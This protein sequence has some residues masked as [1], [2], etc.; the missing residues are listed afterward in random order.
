MLIYIALSVVA[1]NH[2][3]VLLKV[4][5]LFNL[6]SFVSALFCHVGCLLSESDASQFLSL[7]DF[8]STFLLAVLEQCFLDFQ[9]L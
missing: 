5:L 8:F 7:L 2:L 9:F 3:S 1:Q 4:E 6:N